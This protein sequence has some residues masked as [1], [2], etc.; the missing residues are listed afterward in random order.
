M[1]SACELTK[2]FML[3][4]YKGI[5]SRPAWQSCQHFGSLSFS[6][7]FCVETFIA[8]R[9][10]KE[11]EILLTCAITELFCPWK[12]IARSYSSTNSSQEFPPYGLEILEQAST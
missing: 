1:R 9:G 4:R 5:W 12:M 6:Q 10:L 2:I 7:I 3:E 8:A 11:P